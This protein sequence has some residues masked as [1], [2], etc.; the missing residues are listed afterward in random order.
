[1]AGSGGP[2]GRMATSITVDGLDEDLWCYIPDWKKEI[3][4]VGSQSGSDEGFDPTNPSEYKAAQPRPLGAPARTPTT[5]ETVVREGEGGEDVEV[6]VVT[7]GG[8]EVAEPSFEERTKGAD[9]GRGGRFWMILEYEVSGNT[10]KTIMSYD[11]W[12][13]SNAATWN[14]LQ[15]KWNNLYREYLGNYFESVIR[16]RINQIEPLGIPIEAIYREPIDLDW[17]TGVIY[18]QAGE[19]PYSLKGW[20]Q[21]SSADRVGGVNIEDDLKIEMENSERKLNEGIATYNEIIRE[22][23]IVI[24]GKGEAAGF[25]PN[26]TSYRAAEAT[27]EFVSAETVYHGLNGSITMLVQ[28]I[29]NLKEEIEQ[30]TGGRYDR[31]DRGQVVTTDD[32]DPPNPVMT[33]FKNFRRIVAGLEELERVPVRYEVDSE[34]TT[35]MNNASIR[36]DEKDVPGSSL[37]SNPSY[38]ELSIGVFGPEIEYE[39]KIGVPQVKE[40]WVLWN[41]YDVPTNN[42]QSRFNFELSMETGEERG[43]ID[44][45]NKA[46]RWKQE[47]PQ[48][49][50]TTVLPKVAADEKIVKGNLNTITEYQNELN[51]LYD[52]YQQC[53][54]AK[55]NAAAQIRVNEKRL[56]DMREIYDE[57]SKLQLS[58]YDDTSDFDGA[59][60]EV[61]VGRDQPMLLTTKVAQQWYLRFRGIVQRGAIDVRNYGPPLGGQ[62]YQLPTNNYQFTY[63]AAR[64]SWG[65]VGQPRRVIDPGIFKRFD[66][67]SPEEMI[68]LADLIL[69][70]LSFGG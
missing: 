55:K 50:N 25:D 5:T 21:L 7:G 27:N 43:W 11:I 23:N 30:L 35:F 28:K 66:P 17:L 48:L 39:W 54:T 69:G 29:N 26:I 33:K 8:E 14:L 41:E 40:E 68:E 36:E 9:Y 62:K 13:R 65:V 2:L 42:F 34:T 44:R 51:K 60:I 16:K 3:N 47:N 38:I 10:Y 45:P 24:N 70:D 22:N 53:D 18:D 6:V 4:D 37:D 56:T 58:I 67:A 63:D 57:E 52:H 49:Y 32:M 1:M 31:D 46:E 61:D 12:R 59:G 15:K 64:R 20:D 19:D